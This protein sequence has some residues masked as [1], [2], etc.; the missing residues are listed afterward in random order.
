[1]LNSLQTSIYQHLSI[2]GYEVVDI[3]DE[4]IKMPYLKL[5]DTKLSDKVLKTG[6]KLHYISWGLFY[7]YDGSG[8]GRKEVNSKYMDIYE[9]LYEMLYKEVG[10]YCIID[11]NLSHDGNNGI[12]EHYI[13]ENT[14]LYQ[15]SITF[16][17]ILKRKVS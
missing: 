10:E 1:M 8:K 14:I 15:A 17:F 7:W 3:I 13:D 16:D 9:S 4:N 5:G 11:C 12:E 6:E 2:K